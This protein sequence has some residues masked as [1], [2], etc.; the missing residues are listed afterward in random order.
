MCLH[1]NHF[2]F[3]AAPSC[4]AT[5]MVLTRSQADTGN[6]APKLMPHVKPEVMLLS[7]ADNKSPGN[8]STIL[9][10]KEFEKVPLNKENFPKYMKKCKLR[11]HEVRELHFFKHSK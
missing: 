2:N 7:I 11:L 9:K 8:L 10:I 5:K 1:F 3:E 4:L 6:K